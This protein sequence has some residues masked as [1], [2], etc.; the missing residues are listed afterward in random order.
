M[1]RGYDSRFRNWIDDGRAS[2]IESAPGRYGRV[3]EVHCIMRSTLGSGAATPLSG[4]FQDP[5][6]RVFHTVGAPVQLAPCADSWWTLTGSG[7]SRFLQPVISYCAGSCSGSG[8]PGSGPRPAK[9][10]TRSA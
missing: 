3:A 8:I 9:S 5:R 4:V 10:D 2:T 1:R 6:P 7:R